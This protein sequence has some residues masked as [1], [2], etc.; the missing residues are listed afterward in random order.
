[1]AGSMPG[2]TASIAG[3]TDDTCPGCRGRTGGGWA[4]GG[5]GPVRGT[6]MP[7]LEAGASLATGW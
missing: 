7:R 3:G 6:T 4:P 5:H 2:V 1:M